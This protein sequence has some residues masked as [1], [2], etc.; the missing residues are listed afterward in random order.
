MSGSE[1]RIPVSTWI[2]PVGPICKPALRAKSAFGFTPIPS[3]TRSAG[4]RPRLVST[5]VT[6]P[7]PSKA[8]TL[9]SVMTVTPCASKC[10]ST[11]RAISQSNMRRIWGIISTSVT[12]QSHSARASTA[13]T[14]IKPPP[15]ITTSRALA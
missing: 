9:V 8:V 11:N 13:S 12:R 6:C 10:R 5:P 3:T 4:S 15:I 1:L 7:S 2:A 14:P